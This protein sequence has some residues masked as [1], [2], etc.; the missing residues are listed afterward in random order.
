MNTN[1]LIALD[2]LLSVMQV[3]NEL[4]ALITKASGEGRDLSDDELAGLQAKREAAYAK[5]FGAPT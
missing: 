4:T 2:A 1:V 3:A 5:V